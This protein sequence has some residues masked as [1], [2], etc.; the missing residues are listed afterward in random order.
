M[1]YVYIVALLA[2]A[3]YFVFGVL[4]GKARG[5]YGVKAPAVT[6][7][8]HF[9]RAFRVQMN[10]LEQLV[11]F[12]PSLL[13]AAQFWSGPLVSGL[14]AVYLVGRAIY[15]QA[16]VADPRRRSLGFILTVLPSI[17]LMLMGLAGAVLGR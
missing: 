9:E 8:E 3:Q 1:Q 14:G 16:Y 2:V 13:I 7:N 15:R 5:Q 4:V 6:G 10:T 12:L 11:V 17:V